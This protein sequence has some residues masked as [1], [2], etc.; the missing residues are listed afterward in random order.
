MTL[1]NLQ[2]TAGTGSM[3]TRHT[4]KCL[5]YVVPRVM[6]PPSLSCAIERRIFPGHSYN[7]YDRLAEPKTLFVPRVIK[8]LEGN[9]ITELA[10]LSN[11]FDRTYARHRG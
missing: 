4:S 10:F 8:V 7:T 1:E 9:A 3:R 11:E 6:P 2:G 5:S